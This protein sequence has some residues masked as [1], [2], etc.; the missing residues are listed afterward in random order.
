VLQVFLNLFVPVEFLK[1][2][3]LVAILD[4]IIDYSVDF[5]QFFVEFVRHVLDVVEKFLLRRLLHLLSLLC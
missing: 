5:P 3:C 2:V 1:E 4:D